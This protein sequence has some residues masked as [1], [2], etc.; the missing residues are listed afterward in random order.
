[1]KLFQFSKSKIERHPLM[2]ITI[3]KKTVI[4]VVMS[5]LFTG[6]VITG[7]AQDFKKINIE[8]EQD[9]INELESHPYTNEDVIGNFIVDNM[10]FDRVDIHYRGAYYLRQLIRNGPLRNWKIKTSKDQKFENRREWNFNYEDF[11]RQNLSY[12]IYREAGVP[13][14][15]TENVI[16]SVNS[17]KQGLY[18]KYEDCDNKDWL[19]E[20]FG[21]DEGDLYKA[22]YDLPDEKQYFAALTYLGDQ[23]EDYFLHYRKKTNN[24][25]EKEFDYSSIR[26]FLSVVNHTPDELFESVIEAHFDVDEFIRYLIVTNFTANWVAYPIRPKNFWLYNDPADNLWHFIPWDLDNTFLADHSRNPLNTTGTVFFYF[27]GIED[28]KHG[29]TEPLER[30]LVWRIMNIER[31]RNKYIYEYQQA[32]KSYLSVSHLNEVIDSIQTG[33]E[34]NTSGSELSNYRS[35]VI[36]TRDFIQKRHAAVTNELD[37]YDVSTS[38]FNL[39]RANNE[40]NTQLLVFP[41]PARNYV[42]IRLPQDSQGKVEIDIKNLLGQSVYSSTNVN[43]NVVNSLQL[44]LPGIPAGTYIL[45]V[46]TGRTV[47]TT[48]LSIIN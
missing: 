23:N 24:N 37:D 30:P 4:K 40:N 43:H 41:N 48:K 1:V 25:D 20:T 27:D 31:F 19:A 32:T 34:Q 21:D 15:S 9:S 12:H 18:L 10:R 22:A 36:N 42:N 47:L 5:L 29:D 3:H 14:I 38:V 8:I 26:D 46:K 7:N 17:I 2:K 6:F 16:L 39:K 28:Y 13:C 35:D 44:D 33:V 45:Y 11:I